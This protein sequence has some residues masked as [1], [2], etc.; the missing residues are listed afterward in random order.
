[1][2]LKGTVTSA[3]LTSRGGQQR[4]SRKL[5]K[6]KKPGNHFSSVGG[7]PLKCVT[8]KSLQQSV[9][10]HRMEEPHVPW[11]QHVACNMHDR[12]A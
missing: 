10:G 5:A 3:L 7:L 11:M 8:L 6:L 9:P 1:M 4:G 2:P 12:C